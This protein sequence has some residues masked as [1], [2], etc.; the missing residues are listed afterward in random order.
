MILM[1]MCDVLGDVRRLVGEDEMRA[2][3]ASSYI[4]TTAWPRGSPRR[5]MQAAC[6][7]RF[8][9]FLEEACVWLAFW[10]S[11][12]FFLLFFFSLFFTGA[13]VVKLFLFLLGVFLELSF[14][15]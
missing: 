4:D 13:C 14:P 15:F 3:P 2:S 6:F 10:E 9:C 1:K 12:P 11:S 5:Q 7:S 8:L